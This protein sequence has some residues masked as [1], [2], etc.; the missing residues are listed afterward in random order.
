MTMMTL[1]K[2]VDCLK[3][4]ALKRKTFYDNTPPLN[5]GFI[6]QNGVLSFD[7]IGLVKAV[8]N[9]PDIATKKSPVGFYVYP[10]GADRIIPDASELCILQLCSEV[11]WYFNGVAEGEYLYKAGH[12]GVFVGTFQDGGEVNTIECTTDWGAN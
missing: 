2:W 8:I 10:T 1:K 3:H 9:Y 12:A 5:C 11:R 7:C 4:I 6:H